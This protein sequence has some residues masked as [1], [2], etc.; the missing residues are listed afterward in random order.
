M[1]KKVLKAEE[2]K[3]FGRKVST[4]RKT[5]LIP[6]NVY[7]TK[8]KSLAL[9]V[10]EKEFKI[11]YKEVGETGLVTLEVGKEEK[12]VL[13]HS[14]QTNAKTDEVLHIDFLQVDLKVKVTAKV[15]VEVVGEPE[16]EKQGVGT[17]VQY[18]NEVEV[19]ALPA[20]LLEKFE[21]D[22]TELAEVDQAIYVKDLK[23]DKSKIEIMT[24]GESIIVKV[25]PPQKEEEVITPIVAVGAEGEV[26]SEGESAVNG[27]Q[28]T[29]APKEGSSD[30]SA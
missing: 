3:I 28:S 6:A 5:G 26:V 4:L 10:P 23:Y 25:E 18:L 1:D 8:V 12:P 14:I 16:A 29:E 7:G 11:I 15:P 20:D 9:Q 24:D 19:E 21:V 27:E 30:Q 2:R 17:V 13:V 22:T